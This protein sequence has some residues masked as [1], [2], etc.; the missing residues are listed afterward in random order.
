M[1]AGKEELAGVT[2]AVGRKVNIAAE[3]LPENHCSLAAVAPCLPSPPS[4]TS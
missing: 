3:M 2:A 4:S 1:T